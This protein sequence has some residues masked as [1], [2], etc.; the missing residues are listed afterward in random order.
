MCTL[1]AK[2]GRIL[3][4]WSVDNEA[5]NQCLRLDVLFKL[6]LILFGQTTVK[7]SNTS[8]LLTLH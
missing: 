5:S 8:G 1:E 6:G 2:A 4:N 7:F 3:E